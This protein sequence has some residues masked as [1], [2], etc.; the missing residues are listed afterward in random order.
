MFISFVTFLIIFIVFVCF[1]VSK[2]HSNRRKKNN[3]V[4]L[5]SKYRTAVDEQSEASKQTTTVTYSPLN[6]SEEIANFVKNLVI[7][8]M[9]LIDELLPYSYESI[10]ENQDSRATIES[11]RIIHSN[12]YSAQYKYEHA[13]KKSLNPKYALQKTF[14][15]PSKILSWFG[16]SFGLIINRLISLFVWI[17]IAFAEGIIQEI[18]PIL[19]KTLLNS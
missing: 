4:Q 6:E 3:V 13:I 5:L 17:T 14:L 12:L 2:I 7:P 18:I 15:L 11:F 10:F 8:D 9:P 16:L 1:Y 19:S